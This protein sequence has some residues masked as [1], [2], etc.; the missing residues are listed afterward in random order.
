MYHLRVNKYVRRPQIVAENPE[1][2]GVVDDT[3][4]RD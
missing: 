4:R 1:R 3:V 2:P